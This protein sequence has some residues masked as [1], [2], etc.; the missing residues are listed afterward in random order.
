MGER[1]IVIV[2]NRGP[3]SFS[4]A[5]DGTPVA[6]RGAGGLV[7]GL[8]PLVAGTDTVWVAAA[9]GDADRR[10]ASSGV[11]EH[12]GVRARL[13]DL[14]VADHRAAYDVIG[15]ATLWFIHHGL[16]DLARRP[17]FDATWHE[18]WAA[19]R[20]VNGVYAAV[21]A[22]EA[23][24]G[25]VV[26][27]QDYHLA[28]VGALL[29]PLRPDVRVVH[30]THTPFAGPDLFRVLPGSGREELLTGMA[31]HA[32]C[33]FHS[34]RWRTA[35]LHTCA[36]AA[37]AA[38]HTFVAPLG[39]DGNDLARAASSD[40]CADARAR[41]TAAAAGRRVIARVDR[42]E[43]SKNIVRGFLAYDDLL[44]RRPEHRGNVVFAASLYP[45]REG[46]ADYLA[47]RQEV[48][49]TVDRVNRRW[50]T[51][52]WTP[53]L[54]DES[55][56]FPASVALLCEYDVLLVNPV[57]DGLNL[58]AKEGPLVNERSGVLVLSPE[59]GAWDEL[60]DAAIGA[61]PCDITATADALHAA[62]TL[63]GP[64]RTERAERLRARAG[65]RTPADWLADQLV[66]AG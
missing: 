34:E 52:T 23:P 54:L 36:D 1:P 48:A 55:D 37:V 38:P 19:Y 42:I 41:M 25:A 16:F 45:S 64:E 46:L 44:E 18:A 28:L 21:L 30:F 62:L 50:A 39:P 20:R 60:G 56:D 31:G 8:A 3:L 61:D 7:S 47:Y 4:V 26:L 27:V 43:L 66:A 2:S 14:D 59:A 5:D 29:A 40:A 49:A 32:A 13:L 10:A 12:D 22:E 24:E 15:N 58:V 9:M 63:H 35:F 53:I 17:R 65:A 57:R 11:A 51:D 33:G 6:R